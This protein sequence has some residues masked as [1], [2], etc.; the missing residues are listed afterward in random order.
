LSQK[1]E[2]AL[3]LSWVSLVLSAIA[4]FLGL[5]ALSE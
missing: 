5:A 1:V 3:L 2:L 4:V